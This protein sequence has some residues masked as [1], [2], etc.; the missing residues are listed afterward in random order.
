M[1][2]IFKEEYVEKERS[3]TNSEYEIDININGWKIEFLLEDLSNKFIV[4][5]FKRCLLF[6]NIIYMFVPRFALLTI[7]IPLNS[8]LTKT[9]H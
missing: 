1:N 6:T 3:A 9:N 7:T 8:L 5:H 4:S 2:P